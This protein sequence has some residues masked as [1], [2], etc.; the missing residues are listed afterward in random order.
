MVQTIALHREGASLDS[1]SVFADAFASKAPKKLVLITACNAGEKE[2]NI[3][4][5]GRHALH[6][7]A[8][9]C[10]GFSPTT[11]AH[12]QDQMIWLPSMR[13][14]LRRRWKDAEADERE[15]FRENA[16]VSINDK[17]RSISYMR[18]PSKSNTGALVI[19]IMIS[20]IDFCHLD[21]LLR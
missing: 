17:K 14:N 11:N 6:C 5:V 21:T 16:R 7:N 20:A 9:P 18:S 8:V 10:D 19:I 12:A 3:L 2:G 4:V 13:P 15:D 1:L